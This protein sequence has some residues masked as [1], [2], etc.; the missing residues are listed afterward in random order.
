MLLD[1][2]LAPNPV[3][4]GSSAGDA[5]VSSPDPEIPFT[6]SALLF[7][8]LF[9]K[10]EGRD[11]I[12]YPVN[13]CEGCEKQR[14]ETVQT[15][16]LF[17]LYLENTYIELRVAKPWRQKGPKVDKGKPKEGKRGKRAAT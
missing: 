9:A 1:A 3:N 6:G 14:K 8:S 11:V 10:D 17:Y 16:M 15:M 12:M 4:H 5:R 13:S 7:R 2:T